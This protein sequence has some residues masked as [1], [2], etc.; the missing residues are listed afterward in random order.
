M[1]CTALRKDVFGDFPEISAEDAWKAMETADKEKDMDDFK[2][3]R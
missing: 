1:D 3:V 2:I